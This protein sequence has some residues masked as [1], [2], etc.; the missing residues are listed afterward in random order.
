MRRF[1]IGAVALLAVGA[2]AAYLARDR[3]AAAVE[4]AGVAG[5]RAPSVARRR[6]GPGLHPRLR[7]HRGAREHPEL[8]GASSRASSSCR[9]TKASRSRPGRC[10]PGS[11]MPTTGSRSRSPQAALDERTRQLDVAQQNVA[12]TRRT[13][14]SDQAEVSLRAA[15]IRPRPDAP[16]QRRRHD[17]R[18]RR[19]R[20]RA[21]AGARR[22]RPRQRARGGR[23]TNVALAHRRDRRRAQANLDLAKITLG[24]TTLVAPFD[25]VILVRQAE[26]GEVVVA[27]RGDR[28]A[29]RHRP[30][31]AARL[32]Q[33]DRHRQGPARRGRDRH[34]RTRSRARP[35]RGGSRSS[36][37]RPSSR[38]KASRPTRSG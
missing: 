24:Y 23:R 29:R 37:S 28:D 34:H 17:R 1:L 35:I 20:D 32:H 7:Q 10:S 2:S 8:Q 4:G 26:L 11:T 14:V 38:R 36:P 33:R 3:L 31:V 5:R 12:A 19:R 9:S 15:R 27:G 25:G 13:I 30:R 22:A 18:A 21:R 6:G 16:H